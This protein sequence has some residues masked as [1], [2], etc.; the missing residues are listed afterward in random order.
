MKKDELCESFV[1]LL[2]VII[3]NLI[4]VSNMNKF[5]IAENKGREKFREIVKQN[6]L[7][8][9]LEF[10]DDAY[11]NV[12]AYFWFKGKKYAVEIKDRYTFYSSFNIEVLKYNSMES[13]MKS[14]EIDGYYFAV[15]YKDTCYLYDHNTI[16]KCYEDFGISEMRAKKTTMRDSEFT[17]K[18]V[19]SLPTDR[20]KI[21]TI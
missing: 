17:I 3:N 13:L 8:L 9:N 19:I 7:I 16:K 12:D 14:G 2:K 4:K 6:P 10:T 5:M 15:F 18:K 1:F 20:A 21:K 11:N